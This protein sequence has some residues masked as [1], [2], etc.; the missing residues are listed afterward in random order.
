LS[1]ALEKPCPLN[2]SWQPAAIAR[3]LYRAAAIGVVTAICREGEMPYAA[4]TGFLAALA[5]QAAMAA[6][7]S[8]LLSGAREKVALERLA[9]ELHGSVSQSLSGIQLRAPWAPGPAID[10]RARGRGRRLV[11]GRQRRRSLHPGRGQSS[12]AAPRHPNTVPIEEWGDVNG[13]P[14]VIT[15]DEAALSLAESL[16][17]SRV[18]RETAITMLRASPE[19]STAPTEWAFTTAAWR[20]PL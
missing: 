13:M 8:R 18:D 14:F 16:A 3:L 20:R 7:N 5:D 11:R 12:I 1:E 19:P 6:A 4:E 15:P 9:R 10:A 17:N 2:L